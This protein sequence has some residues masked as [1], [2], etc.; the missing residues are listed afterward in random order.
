VISIGGALEVTRLATAA[1]ASVGIFCIV[2]GA[3]CYLVAFSFLERKEGRRRN[4]YTYT[5][6]GLAL[7]LTGCYILSSGVALAT[8][9]SLL[10]LAA[11]WSG[12][13]FGRT[14]L[15]VHAAAYL[16]AAVVASGLIVF[17]YDRIIGPAAQWPAPDAG[18]LIVAVA[19]ACSY[20]LNRGARGPATRIPAFAI[21]L[22]LCWS[23]IALLAGAIAPVEPGALAALRTAI[24]CLIAILLSWAGPR[25]KRQELIWLLYPLIA[26]GA[27]KLVAEDFRQGR[28]VTM[29]LSLLCYGGALV[30]VPRLV[31]RR[32]AR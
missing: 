24:L 7:I 11:M 30:L 20:F 17:G 31:R 15:R 19:A 10:A 5:S 2:S 32:E 13:R 18:V 21:G 23:V 27:L 28:A 12:E 9:C 25:W 22:L 16:L 3:A 6:F 4:L 26:L 1:S 29:S 14:S 8:I